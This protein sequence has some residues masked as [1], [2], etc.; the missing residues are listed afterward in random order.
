[1]PSVEVLRFEPLLEGV[2]QRRWKRFLS[3]VQLAS[4][5]LV[6]AH[7]ANT[8][9]MTG[10]L[11]PGG[12]VRVRHDPSPK[13]KLAYTWEQAEMPADGGWVGVNTALPNRLLRATIEAGLLEPWLGPVASVRAEVTYGRERR[14]RIDLLLQPAPEAEDQRPI[15][16][17]IKNT[18]WSAADLALFPDTVTERGQKHLEELIHV[19]PDARAVLIPCVSRSDVTRFAPGDSADPRYGE[20]FREAID[21]GVE[22]IPCQFSFAVDAV[23]FEGVLPVQRTESG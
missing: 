10:V 9:P 23:R 17:E 14:S 6:T 16:V 21:A 8:G 15:Y 13:R 20:L 12:R 2:L 7:C 19:L 22:V 4:G 11:H 1:M 3:E 5:E 18:T